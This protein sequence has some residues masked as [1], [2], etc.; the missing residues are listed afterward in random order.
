MALFLVI[1]P[2]DTGLVSNERLGHRWQ[3]L[4]G[5]EDVDSNAWDFRRWW[6][7]GRKLG[8]TFLEQ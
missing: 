5:K 4:A 1:L 7:G 2:L 6:P 8:A 3:L